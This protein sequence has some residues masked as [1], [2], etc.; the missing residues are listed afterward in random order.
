[1]PDGLALDDGGDLY[2]SCYA[3]DEIWK[4]D[5]RGGK[6]LF[7]WDPFAISLSRPTNMAFME[8]TMYVANLG[9]TTV[10]RAKVGVRGM[11]L[12]NRRGKK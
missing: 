5:P 3:S 10:T 7:G 1:M 9:R 4:V 12:V 6:T 2:V 8:D 11:E